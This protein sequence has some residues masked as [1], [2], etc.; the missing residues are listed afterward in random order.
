MLNLT[1]F[2]TIQQTHLLIFIWAH[3]RFSV[4]PNEEPIG[5]V[6]TQL[7]NTKLS[8]TVTYQLLTDSQMENRC[9]ELLTNKTRPKRL[10]HFLSKLKRY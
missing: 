1:I 2:D 4:T 3:L 7:M 8:A 9:S 5:V 6:Y 10:Q